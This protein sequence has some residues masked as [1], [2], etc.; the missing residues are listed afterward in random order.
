MKKIFK[1]IALTLL[2]VLT[3]SAVT[4]CSAPAAEELYIFN[5][6]GENADAM[7]AAADA[8]TAE[9][10]IKTKVFSLGSGTDSTEIMRTEINSDT[11][12][13][14]FSVMNAE[15]LLEWVES[16]YAS[17]LTSAITEEYKALVE[18]IPSDFHLTMDGETNYGI[19]FNI[20]G[21]GF[22][23][24]TVM[25]ADI[26]G[27]DGKE[28]ADAIKTAT[29]EEWEATVLALTDYIDNGNATSVTLS[30]QT[31]D[32][33]E[34]KTGRATTLE[35]VFSTAGSEKWT[36]GD[37]FINVALNA[38]FSNPTD[39]RDATKA[40]VEGILGPMTAYAQA[41]DLK[42]GNAVTERS[43]DFI[44]STTNGY[45][46]SVEN[47]AS[48][49]AIFLKQGN[50]VYG[51]FA[52]T[53]NP[54]IV[55]TLTFVPVKM[56]L[57]DA[58]VT[59]EGRTVDSINS[60]IP[61]FVP[62]YYII[63]D[64]VSDQEKEWAEQFLVWLNTSEAGQKF[65]TEDMNFIPYNADPAT[66]TVSNS[67][68]NSIIEY[69]NEGNTISNPYAGAPTTWTGDIVGAYVMENYLT[70]PEWTEEN[71]TD[72][73]QYSIDKWVELKGLE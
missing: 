9:T 16:G 6:K 54:E 33:A 59:V 52:N 53:S 41:L 44:N 55:D 68:G 49:K 60:S 64:K 31:F 39:A 23:V 1:T 22:V 10:G 12:P 65:V 45:D 36:Y 28:V 62:N 69:L 40:E 7:Q 18:T 71:Y 24:D 26:F 21:Y 66:T 72:I 30:G 14:I 42:T 5:T 2:A 63:N 17:P 4:A 43:A 8:F 13:A 48:G 20:E 47:L 51:N 15:S 50:W 38:T 57:T 32:M 61:V 70:V 11:K 3:L 27:V 56:P 35:G 29:Y 67:L 73:A 25:L 58:D 37:H 34:E 19:P 46:P